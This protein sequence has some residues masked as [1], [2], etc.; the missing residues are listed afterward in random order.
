[1]PRGNE[2][3]VPQLERPLLHRKLSHATAKRARG[4]PLNPTQPGVTYIS[5]K[6]QA[7]RQREK[8]ELQMKGHAT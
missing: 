2:A 1:M 3:I 8:S 4:L 7:P 6:E 5:K